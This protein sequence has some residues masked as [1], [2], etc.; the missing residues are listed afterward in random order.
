MVVPAD[1]ASPIAA[2]PWMPV[3]R[4]AC[5][6]TVSAW[7]SRWWASTTKSA[8]ARANAAWRAAR[9]AASVP[10]GS[11]RSMR[12]R[13]TCSGTPRLIGWRYAT[14]GAEGIPATVTIVRSTIRYD[15]QDVAA[16]QVSSPEIGEREAV[17]IR[18]ASPDGLAQRTLVYFPEPFGKTSIHSFNLPEAEVLKV[19]E[20]VAEAT[21]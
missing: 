14:I 2:R 15:T 21:R 13:A 3:P 20:A 12:T 5:R 11:S 1:R 19:A 9:A 16:S 18:A 7:S 17:I 8:P 10:E 6:S 4:I